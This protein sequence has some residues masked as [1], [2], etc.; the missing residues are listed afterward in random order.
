MINLL[1]FGMAFALTAI[2]TPLVRRFALDH[3]I[4]DAPNEERKI[5]KHPIAYLGGV[6][7][8]ISFAVTALCLMAP[9][10]QLTALLIGC[11]ILALI[12][13]IDDIR[14]LSP[15]TKLFFQF[16]AAG[17]ALG[18]GIGITTI[19]NP[20]GGTIDLT[21]GRF[22]VSMFGQHFHIT[23]IANFLSILW[24]VGLANTI[25]FLDG[26]DGLAGGVSGIGAVI[27]FLLAISPR[28]NQPA[29]ALLAI[30]LAGVA[31]G[32]LPY[33]FYPARIFMGDSGSLFLGLVLAMLAI[34]SGAKLATATLV[35]GFPIF[36]AV[37]AVTRRI[38]KG[39]SPFRADRQH[40]HHLLLDAGLSQRQAVLTLYAVA[41][42]F[43]LVA[44]RAGS[45]GKLLAFLVLGVFMTSAIAWLTF[46]SRARARK[47]LS[48]D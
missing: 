13:A 40:F 35:L 23:P 37:W 45:F 36:D 22:G 25:N 11:G 33:N 18:G 20:L 28:V 30:I 16:L 19:S 27:M 17:I 42:V 31:F 47:L 48:K 14:K 2:L 6:A 32:F 4:I 43:G 8:F 26:L 15:W 39:K 1:G 46:G 12:G 10:R 24:M 29:V 38:A 9:S 44:L 34:Y 41:T 21:V 5:H 3:N 7:M